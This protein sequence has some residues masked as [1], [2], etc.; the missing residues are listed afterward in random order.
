[1]KVFQSG[2]C[3]PTALLNQPEQDVLGADEI[4]MKASLRA[5]V[6]T[7]RALSVNLSN[8]GYSLIS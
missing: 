6:I 2:R 1:M 3:D 8:M 7:F 4:V 5:S